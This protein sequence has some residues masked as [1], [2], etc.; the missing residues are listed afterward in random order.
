MALG[1]F[2]WGGGEGATGKKNVVGTGWCGGGGG[3]KLVGSLSPIGL[4]RG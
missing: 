2:V 3:A 1:V 4:R